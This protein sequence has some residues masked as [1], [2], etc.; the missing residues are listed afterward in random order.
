[1]APA[2]IA[3]PEAENADEGARPDRIGAC[4]AS[5][6]RAMTPSDYGYARLMEPALA[7]TSEIEGW[8]N[9][10][11]DYNFLRVY[12]S[13]ARTL[14]PAHLATHIVNGLVL[15][16]ASA[17][18]TLV[19]RGAG[20]VA[21]TRPQIFGW[22]IG[23]TGSWKTQSQM[24]ATGLIRESSLITLLS[25]RPASVEV[26]N[27]ELAS[28]PHAI[29]Y[30]PEFATFL[31]STGGTDGMGTR[32]RTG[33]TDVFDGDSF[34]TTGLR[35]GKF[36][37]NN[38]RVSILAAC[39]PTHITTH[40]T[41]DDFAGGFINRFLL[42]YSEAPSYDPNWQR[43]TDHT[44]RAWLLEWLN[45]ALS[46]PVGECLGMNTDAFWMWR[47]WRDDWT[48]FFLGLTRAEQDAMTRVPLLAMRAALAAAWGS[49]T[50]CNANWHLQPEHILAGIGA[51]SMHVASAR[52]LLQTVPKT[53]DRREVN[54]VLAAIREDWT[55]LGEITRM[56]HVARRKV[57]QH[58]ETLKEEGL[59]ATEAQ[60]NST[61]YRRTNGTPLM[62]DNSI[63]NLPPPPMVAN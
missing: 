48:K 8:V 9:P 3:N 57:L 17:H 42:S 59:V 52:M 36:T 38:P 23:D 47:A 56:S 40:T 44:R 58:L 12:L 34:E 19:A 22:V 27:K 54:T 26:F 37:V 14:T 51:V 49:S 5:A 63:V 25:A 29:L 50:T 15:C 4:V 11:P 18:P 6:V 7:T 43:G 35:S 10:L 53:A 61:F 32:L 24:I 31:A 33:I 16:G 41:E 28:Q 39:A 20:L 62:Y 21:D 45:G 13:Y 55:A 2:L 1:M 30:Y 46:R 60:N